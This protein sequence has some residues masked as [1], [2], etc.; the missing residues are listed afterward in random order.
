[1]F[2]FVEEA[3]DQV[4]LSASAPRDFTLRDAPTAQTR[5]QKT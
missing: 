5:I 4:A 3:F 2:E 1:M